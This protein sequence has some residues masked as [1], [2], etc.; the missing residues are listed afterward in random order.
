[1][2]YRKKLTIDA[3]DKSQA[4]SYANWL[5]QVL[6]MI[7]PKSLYLVSGRGSSKTTEFQ[8]ER[9]IEMVYDMP[10]SPVCWVSDTYS[11]LQKNVLPMVLEGLERKG[12]IEG[13]HFVVE[14]APPVYNVEE[15]EELPEWLKE[16]FWKPFNKVVTYKHTLIFFTGLNVTFASLDR[17][18]SLAGKSYVHVFGDEAKYFPEA[19]I[20]NLL[21]AVRG[22]R[23]KYGNSPFYMGVTFT[24]DMPNTANCGEYDWILKQS[25]NINPKAIALLIKTAC[26]V[27]D[28][29][30]EWLAVTK[31]GEQKDVVAKLR[32]L[33][34]WEDKL[35]GLRSHPSTHIFFY[36]ASSYINVDIL[37]PEWFDKAFSADLGDVKTAILSLRATLEGG[38]RF[39]AN[40][41][42]S[43]FYRDGNDEFFAEQFGLNDSEDCRILRYLKKDKSLDVSVDFGNMMSLLVAQD[44]GSKYRV[45]K[46]IYT[47]SP[48]W[49]REL[50]DKFLRYF[51][52]H[53]HKFINLY[54]DRAGNSYQAA[55]ADLA[56]QLKQALENDIS[57][58]FTGWRVTLM[59]IG[60]STIPQHEEYTFMQS[61]LSGHEN[62]LPCVLIDAYNCKHLKLSL[63]GARTRIIS[64]NGMVAK[65]KRSE[66]LAIDRLPFESTNFSDSFKYL[67]M[68][69]KWRALAAGRKAQFSGDTSVR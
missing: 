47:L 41:S 32:T 5:A 11:N 61:L 17:P 63:E 6:G 13:V 35:Y 1:M 42:E 25:K 59:S 53:E 23:V 19:K 54:Y 10:G 55:K 7:M 24:T 2:S 29:R 62:K 34:R 64:K 66:K 52:P 60:Q 40:I 56:S 43:N 38:D 33:Q 22:Y 26:I 3:D 69:K 36:I 39:Y 67:M 21:K 27:N 31:S 16:Q 49:I 14:K 12:L 18:S 65:D 45:L 46:N 8:V 68:R 30:Q 28:C 57:G 9:L 44:D 58:K 15:K 51:S 48:E 50:A 37:T 4:V 20:A